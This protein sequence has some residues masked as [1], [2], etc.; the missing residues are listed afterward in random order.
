MKITSKFCF[1]FFVAA[2]LGFGLWTASSFPTPEAR[3]F[4]TVIAVPALLAA[5][6][7]LLLDSRKRA[8]DERPAAILD[9]PVDPSVPPGI[10]LLRAARAFG[11]ILGLAALTVLF[12]LYVSLWAFIPAYLMV[13]AK[14]SWR[15][16]V[17]TTVTVAAVIFGVLSYGFGINVPNGLFLR[18]YLG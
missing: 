13:E 9:L 1:T 18:R 2:L 15:T 8:T 7:Q 11:W 17:I 3:Q 14:A 5:M 4:P 10:A 12:S 16:A 6:V